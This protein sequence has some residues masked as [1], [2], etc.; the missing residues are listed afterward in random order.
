MYASI[1]LLVA[2][3]RARDM[4]NEATLAHRAREARLARRAQRARRARRTHTVLGSVQVPDS[5]EDFLCQTAETVMREPTASG[6]ASGQTV[7]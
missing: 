7:R 6:R 5:Y 3:Q 2:E 1:S 4:Q